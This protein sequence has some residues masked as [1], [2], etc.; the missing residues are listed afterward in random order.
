MRKARTEIRWPHLRPITPLSAYDL[1]ATEKDLIRRTLLTDYLRILRK[2]MV[3]AA[4]QM[5]RQLYAGWQ[6]LIKFRSWS[7]GIRR[8]GTLSNGN[9]EILECLSPRDIGKLC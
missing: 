7:W 4:S 6:V 1:H 3:T 8:G 9:L 5:T 2:Y